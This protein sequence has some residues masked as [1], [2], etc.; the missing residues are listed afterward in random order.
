MG[1]KVESGMEEAGSKDGRI[2]WSDL[3]LHGQWSNHHQLRKYQ[4]SAKER[5]EGMMDGGER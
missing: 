5:I 1:I 3:V 2:I 4:N